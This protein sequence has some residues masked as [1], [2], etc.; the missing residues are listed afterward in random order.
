MTFRASSGRFATSMPKIRMEPEVMRRRVART[1]RVVVFPA[2][3]G[4][5]S[6]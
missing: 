1:R 3:F 4:P 6:P 2:P 5:M